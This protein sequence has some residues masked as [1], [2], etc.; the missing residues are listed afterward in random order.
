MWHRIVSQ[1]DIEALMIKFDFF[2]DSCVK[3][4]H[5]VSGTYVENDRSMVMVTEPCI[6][7][8]FN[9]QSSD[10]ISL[11]MILNQVDKF[12][13]NIDL[14]STLEILEAYLE[15]RD[16]KFYWYD[17]KNKMNATYWFSCKEIHWR[18]T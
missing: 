18:M 5:Y 2:H 14:M 11:E 3:E 12:V 1:E 10:Y 8:V 13:I 7:I 16:D 4:F 6:R 17:T 9:S 15:K